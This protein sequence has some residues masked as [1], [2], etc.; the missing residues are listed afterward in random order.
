MGI[1]N[2]IN[3]HQSNAANRA[4]FEWQGL[5]GISTV[6]EATSGKDKKQTYL[7]Q[8]TIKIAIKM[9]YVQRCSLDN[10]DGV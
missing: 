4:A 5:D 8:V 10:E 9:R 3:I 6:V 2:V 1:K 7:L